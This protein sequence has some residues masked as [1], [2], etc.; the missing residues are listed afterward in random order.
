MYLKNKSNITIDGNGSTVIIHGIC[1]PF[2]F[3]GCENITL[4]NISF[5]YARPTMSE[6]DILSRGDDGRYLIHV[7]EDCLFDI[8][9][10]D[11]VWHGEVG[12]DG[13]YLWE[14][15]YRDPM[16]LS[17]FKDLRTEWVQMLDGEE[18][19]PFPCIP[20]IEEIERIDRSTVLV[21]LKNKHA[22]FPIG[23]TVQTRHVVRDQIGGCFERCKNV[24]FCDSSIYAMHGFGILA[25]FCENVSYDNLRVVPRRGRSIASNADFFHFSGCKGDLRITGCKLEGGHDDFI[26]IH[27]TYLKVV[28]IC[29]NEITARFMNSQSRGFK[30]FDVGD[31]IAFVST[32]TLI[33]YCTHR[34]AEC[35]MLDDVTFRLKL[36]RRAEGAKGDCIENVTWTPS[37][38][39]QGNKFGPSMGRGVLC[40][41]RKRAVIRDNVFYKT[42]GGVLCIEDDCNFWF[43]SGCVGEIEFAD[44][45]IIGCAYGKFRGS[46]LPV[47]SCLPQ[48][49]DKNAIVYPHGRL[50]VRNNTFS[51]LQSASYT[52]L[53]NNLQEFVFK[54]NTSDEEMRF[55]TH[56]VGQM[57]TE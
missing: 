57:I 49:L 1:T 33:P 25:Q 50:T 18:R 45:K 12:S 7:H 6:F 32:Q 38:L 56:C 15:N 40:I 14:V 30:A 36:D 43:E 22:F 29:E 44:N 54:D 5:D 23:S 35:E 51:D 9:G 8:V 55:K 20:E 10:S 47:I 17:T 37:V 39:I 13:K 21:S 4:K 42:G 52:V 48:V 24:C 31:E 26:N 41:T 3:D 11:I 2:V 19:L 46:P 53:L 28:E 16:C 27:G 34:V